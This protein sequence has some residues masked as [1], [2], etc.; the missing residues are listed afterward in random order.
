[1]VKKDIGVTQKGFEACYTDDKPKRKIVIENTVEVIV[2]WL[3]LIIFMGV[4]FYLGVKVHFM[5]WLFVGF[6]GAYLITQQH[7]SRKYVQDEEVVIGTKTY[8]LEAIDSWK[9]SKKEN[10][11]IDFDVT[12]VEETL[13]VFYYNKKDK[14]KYF[15]LTPHTHFGK[16]YTKGT[17]QRFEDFK[18]W[19]EYYKPLLVDGKEVK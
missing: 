13:M 4:F 1:M 9:Y 19:L 3:F 8:D 12:H 14:L 17:K 2:T 6:M 11:D 10:Y 7:P 5:F 15:V 16:F 18:K